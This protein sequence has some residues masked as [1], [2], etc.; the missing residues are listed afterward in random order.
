MSDILYEL[1]GAFYFGWMAYRHKS[2][3]LWW[4]SIV[5]VGLCLLVGFCNFIVW[6]RE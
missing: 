1:A 2:D 4:A 6:V 3:W 5:I